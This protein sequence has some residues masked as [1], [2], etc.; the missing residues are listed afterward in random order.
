MKV[1]SKLSLLIILLVAGLLISGILSMNQL[2]KAKKGYLDFKTDEIL[3]LTLK[4]LQYRFTGI[5]NDGRAF[6]LTGDKEFLSEIDEKISEIE[7]YFADFEQMS[8]AN[9]SDRE[10]LNEVKRNL[11]V[12]FD[13]HTKMVEAYQNGDRDKA[14]AIHMEDQREIRKK[15]VDPSIEILIT[16]I[17]NRIKEKEVQLDNTQKISMVVLFLVTFISIVGG[18][19]V[20]IFMIRS[21]NKPIQLMNS[22][23]REI[24]EGEGD[25]TQEIN[26]VS[27]DELGEM[28]SSF[29][30]MIEKLRQLIKQVAAHSEQ[31]AAASEQLTA[32]SEETTKAT[33]QIASTVQEVAEGTDKQ[34]QS[35]KATT[36]TIN[37]LTS[38]V[39]Q[40]AVNSEAA[41]NTAIQA[42]E[43]A[44]DGNKTVTN[45]IKHMDEI[46]ET[47]SQLSHKVITLGER[48]SQIN[49]I[50]GAITGIAEQTNLLALNAA[51]E[52][53]RA[54]EHGR[55]FAVVADE[56]RKLAEQSAASALQIS[57]LI[58]V[59]KTDTDETIQSMT[60]TTNRVTEGIRFIQD[61]GTSFNQIE[62]VVLGVS[63]QIQEVTSVVHELSAGAEQMVQTFELIAETSEIT[64]G[65]TQ[66]MATST[67]EQ[68]AAMEEITASASSLT[69]MA[70][71]LQDL[72]KK[73]KT[74]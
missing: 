33:E 55:G 49:E 26:V 42:S 10:A 4:S 62:R 8:A 60:D 7:G 15:L 61:A 21:I 3:Q 27:R 1:K 56:V 38:L 51:I 5:S 63:S 11:A 54:G 9:A 72:I 71:E 35:M 47:V 25:L 30:L 73:F 48:S 2:N 50:I 46:S 34:V 69:K 41:S 74:T 43:K 20:A 67:E 37:D 58:S 36:K 18:I 59:I 32:S 24:A 52:A 6:L 64:A 44:V 28:A 66:S 23:L 40:I 22:R 19:V 29:N 45:I 65:G 16:E 53:A 12:Y 31:V 14:L 39:N 57:S 70:D 17:D 68:L 13:A